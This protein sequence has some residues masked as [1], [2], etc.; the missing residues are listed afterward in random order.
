MVRSG[1]VYRGVYKDAL[2]TERSG[3]IVI[4]D[5]EL[6]FVRHFEHQCSI[7]RRRWGLGEW[8]DKSYCI[9]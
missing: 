7:T 9:I 8:L 2:G 1:G 6:T 3:G 4:F 5:F